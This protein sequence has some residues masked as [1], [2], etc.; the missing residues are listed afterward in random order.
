MN[1]ELELRLKAI[2][3]RLNSLNLN[4]EVTLNIKSLKDEINKLRKEFYQYKDRKYHI[5]PKVTK[6]TNEELKAVVNSI[7][8]ELNRGVRNG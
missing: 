6:G 7:V 5:I 8:Y 3:D 4:E 2:E 1:E